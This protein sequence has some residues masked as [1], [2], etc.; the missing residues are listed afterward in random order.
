MEIA[1]FDII[2]GE[3]FRVFEKIEMLRRVQKMKSWLSQIET[4]EVDWL[5]TIKGFAVRLI[6]GADLQKKNSSEKKLISCLS[7]ERK[8]SLKANAVQLCC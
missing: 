8:E 1:N 3:S 4:V 6:N 2:F 5:V 7:L